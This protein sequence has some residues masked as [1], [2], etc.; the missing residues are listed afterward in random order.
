MYARTYI[1]L[2]GIFTHMTVSWSFWTGW[3]PGQIPAGPW[4]SSHTPMT[5]TREGWH[6]LGSVRDAVSRYLGLG[7]RRRGR[8]E[9]EEEEAVAVAGPS[10]TLLEP[11]VAS[12]L[13]ALMGA[14]LLPP[15]IGPGRPPPTEAVP[16]CRQ[17]D[18]W[19]C[20]GGVR[21]DGAGMAAA[22]W[23]RRGGQVGEPPQPPVPGRPRREAGPAGPAGNQV[24]L[25]RR[26]ALSPPG[27]GTGRGRG[28]RR[29]RRRRRRCGRGRPRPGT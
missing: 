17:R 11:K 22:G 5:G 6:P 13:V 18:T 23:P 29:R 9:E 16:H 27:G 2:P 21:P 7:L 3:Y 15:R 4:S 24:D 19:D 14:P 8:E 25:D 10:P 20:G 1:L 28:R 12:A 26:S